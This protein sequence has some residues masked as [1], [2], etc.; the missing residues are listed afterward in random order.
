MLAP[1]A[2]L[3]RLRNIGVRLLPGA[4][5]VHFSRLMTRLRINFRINET[6]GVP[7]GVTLFTQL[8]EIRVIKLHRL[9]YRSERGWTRRRNWYGISAM[10]HR[11]CAPCVAERRLG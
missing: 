3:G 2:D 1:S 5:D 11:S 9:R 7:S 8:P 4:S 10:A 6:G